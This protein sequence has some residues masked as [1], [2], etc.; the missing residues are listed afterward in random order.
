LLLAFVRKTIR[1]VITCEIQT[2]VENNGS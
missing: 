2:W 1:E